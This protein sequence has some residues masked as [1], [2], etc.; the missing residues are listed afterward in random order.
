M[1]TISNKDEYT[2]SAQ[3]T[4]GGDEQRGLYFWEK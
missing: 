1:P 4:G 3:F 2:A